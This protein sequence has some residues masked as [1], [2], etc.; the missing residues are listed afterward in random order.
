MRMLSRRGFAVGAGAVAGTL[1]LPA[2]VRG[3]AGY[4]SEDVHFVSGSVAG[5]GGDVIVRFF[6]EQMRPLMGRT[7][8]VDNKVGA[9]SNIAIEHTVRSKPDG[10]TV[11]INS[12]STLAANMKL[13]RKPPFDTAR[14]LQ[15]V[16]TLSRSTMMLAVRADAPWKDVKELTAAMK[17]K[18]DKAT[19]AYATSIAQVIGALYRE[20]AGLKAVEVAYKS[21]ADFVNDLA[22]GNVD[23]AIADHVQATGLARAGRMR[24]LAV[25]SSERLKVTPDIPTFA[26]FG[27]PIDIRTWWGATVPAA[28]PKPVV[29]QLSGWFNKVVTSEECRRFFAGI[30]TDPWATDPDFA[31]DYL[32]KEIVDWEGHMKVAGIAP[33]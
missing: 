22:S 31:Q 2:V 15:M 29:Q 10:H 5:S 17:E 11:L 27:Y 1:A 23:Y 9:M 16:A 7:V 14:D 3:Q 24:L 8:V 19:Y 25:G 30:G 32:R 12:G 20:K 33:Q 21:G 6:A 4:P 13:F 26:E 18:G 28:T